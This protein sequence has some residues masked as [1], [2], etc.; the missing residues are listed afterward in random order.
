MVVFVK[1]IIKIKQGNNNKE[2][3]VRAELRIEVISM[4]DIVLLTIL[5]V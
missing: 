1:Q 2:L 3:N 4:C 5:C